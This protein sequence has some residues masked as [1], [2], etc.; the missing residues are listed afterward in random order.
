MEPLS[1]P[2]LAL[3]LVFA[4]AVV[5]WGWYTQPLQQMVTGI[6]GGVLLLTVVKP[7]SRLAV[8]LDVLAVSIL[9]VYSP[10]WLPLGAWAIAIHRRYARSVALL[11]IPA[12]V[13]RAWQVNGDFL[14]WAILFGVLWLYLGFSLAER[15]TEEGEND[16][17][18]LPLP[19]DLREQ[20][21]QEREAHR[22]LRYQYQELVGAH[23]HLQAQKRV[24]QAC[25]QILRIGIT[26]R[27]PR[28]TARQ[29]VAVLRDT[30]GATDGAIWFFEEHP[31]ALRLACPTDSPNLPSVISLPRKQDKRF[32]QVASERFYN[33]LSAQGQPLTAFLLQDGKD[34]VG[35][36][37]L[38]GWRGESEEP[39]VRDRS[40]RLRDSLSL[41]VRL[42][43]QQHALRE[44]NRMLKALYETGRLLREAQS[45]EDSAQNLT[46]VVAELFSAPFV[47]LYLRAPEP[48]TFRVSAYVGEPIRLADNEQTE[49]ETGI[50]SWFVQRAQPLYLPYTS[51]EPGLIR[52]ASKRVFASLIGVPILVWERLEGV[53]L[54]AHSQPGYFDVV[55]LENLI[56]VANQ[57]AQ[58]LQ[59]SRLTRSVGLLALTDG[60]TGLFNRRYLELRLEEELRRSQ[61]YGKRFSLILVDVDHFKR[62]NDTWGHATG[63]LVLQSV[64]RIL[65][66]NLRETEMVF[67]YGGEE[68]LIILPETPLQQAV[69]IARRLREIVAN[70]LFRTMDGATAF[71]VTFSAGVA[72]YPTHG[73]DKLTLL[74]TVDHALYLA[75]RR[76]RNRVE[77]SP[78]A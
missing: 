60:L 49:A 1:I 53:L 47:T 20:W 77:L 55:Q 30:T 17:F 35:A 3:R 51:A 29:I 73:S 63:D 67:R 10:M 46:T 33:A 74:S 61:R 64:G 28:E 37:A 2:H 59:V 58:L 5:I 39:A 12:L 31:P 69:E 22:Q 23:R 50:I 9:Q 27:E 70:H 43:L 52:Y 13:I 6:A 48:D 78:A 56:A 62:I 25:L 45:V 71:Q 40:Q 8:C 57:F 44:E 65:T 36:V 19:D 4:L 14:W 7:N 41:T 42:A 75:K 72:E 21:E 18:L 15:Q 26:T 34:V 32:L 76:G 11:L 54:A 16:K 66:E 68:L 24:D 38:Y